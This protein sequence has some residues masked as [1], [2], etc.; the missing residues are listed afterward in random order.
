MSVHKTPDGRYYVQHYVRDDAG[1]KKKK[2][3]EYFGRGIEAQ[4]QAETRDAEYKQ[5]GK[6]GM[7]AEQSHRAQS[8]TIA[9]LS[10]AYVEQKQSSLSA[11]SQD[12]VYYKLTGVILPELGNLEAMCLTKN[13]RLDQYVT[14]CLKSPVY[15]K[16]GSSDTLRKIPVKKPDTLS[17][18]PER[19]MFRTEVLLRSF[20]AGLD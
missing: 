10:H 5:T 6:I 2:K 3:K 18:M 4:K 14:K 17:G 1:Y 12:N 11:I 13:Y 20:R 9:E 19:V 15:K 7:Y 16:V 8:P